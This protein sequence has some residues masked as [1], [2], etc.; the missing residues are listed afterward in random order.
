MRIPTL[1]L[2]FC[3]V[4]LVA[5][6]K[7]D[8]EPAP[9][10]SGGTVYIL[11]NPI[12]GIFTW[13]EDAN[14]MGYLQ[15]QNGGG[16]VFKGTVPDSYPLNDLAQDD[17]CRVEIIGRDLNNGPVAYGV[18]MQG[19]E[20]WWVPIE[21]GTVGGGTELVLKEVDLGLSVTEMPDF[22]GY[23]CWIRHQIGSVGGN[24]V[25]AMESHTYPNMY[26]SLIG[27]SFN[28]NSIGLTEHQDPNNAQG[29][30]FR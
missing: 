27:T 16:E 26:W 4:L 8:D 25:Y 24:P 18:N 20:R 3:L 13:D 7:D 29:F 30:I 23:W 11:G 19:T 5:C 21:E 12:P 14:T 10:I 2:S 15:T 28:A 1:L 6:K 22:G 17:N 9:P